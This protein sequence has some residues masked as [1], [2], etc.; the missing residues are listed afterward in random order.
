MFS[1][2]VQI[3]TLLIASNFAAAGELSG[4]RAPSFS[5]PDSNLVYHDIL[6]YRGRVLILELITTTC[7]NCQEMAKTLQLVKQKYAAKVAVISVVIPPDNVGT[8]GK[9]AKENGITTPVLFDCGI[10][11]AAYFKATPSNSS[12]H[13]PH[14][15][16]IDQQGMIQ[17]DFEAPSMDAIQA[18]VDKLIAPAKAPAQKKK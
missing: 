7:P 10:T 1:L 11:A 15:F 13:V 12:I 3:C 8:A 16:V 4:R 18:A 9:F 6:D 2:R 17:D 14:L 5:L